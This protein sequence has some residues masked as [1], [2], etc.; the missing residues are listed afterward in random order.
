MECVYHLNLAAN[1]IQN[2]NLEMNAFL[3]VVL[4]NVQEFY[5]LL[6]QIVS[7]EFVNK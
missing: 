5:V 2:V 7:M 3:E 1:Q 4:V 6:E